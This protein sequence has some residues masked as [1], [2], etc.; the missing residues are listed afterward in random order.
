[1]IAWLWSNDAATDTFQK[2]L[3][4]YCRSAALALSLAVTGVT[5][6]AAGVAGADTTP[7]NPADP[8]TPVTVAA[9]ALLTVQVNGVV[10][11][12]AVIG[13]TVTLPES[14]TGHDRPAP[15]SAPMR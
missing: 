7:T 13:N 10:W 14:S 5:A 3:G 12:Q 15:P 6:G 2:I 1:M 8:K 9:D 4:R 11:Q